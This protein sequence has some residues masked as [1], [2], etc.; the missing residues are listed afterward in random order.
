MGAL[1][2]PQTRLGFLLY[3]SQ[4]PPLKRH[5]TSELGNLLKLVQNKGPVLVEFAMEGST[6]SI[7]GYNAKYFSRWIST[8]VRQNIPP[9]YPS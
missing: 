8:I 7:V 9:C 1:I 3:M 5:S 4:E 2:L 6:F